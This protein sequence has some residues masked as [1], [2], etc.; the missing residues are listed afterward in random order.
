[1]APLRGVPDP[2]PIAI[3]DADLVE[4]ARNGDRWAEDALFRR[5]GRAIAGLVAR[6]LGSTQDVDDVVH[7]TF[8][9]ALEQ[10]AK[11]REPAAFRS[12]LRQIAVMHV[13]MALRKKRL[14]RALGL[15]PSSDDAALEELASN[16]IGP[17]MRAELAVVDGVLRR[18]ATDQR[19]AWMLRY[20]EGYQLE[21]AAK[22]C[23]CSLATYKRR[24]AA[25]QSAMAAVVEIGDER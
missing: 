9:S 19:I 3:G 5:H 20:V 8:V 4:R 25:A 23:D 6:L 21:E 2:E 24:L 11:L 13:R 16:A 10:L 14:R 17:E 15:L 7:D 1:V 18:M 12:W 22:L